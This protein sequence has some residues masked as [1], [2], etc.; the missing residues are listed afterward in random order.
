MPS[1]WLRA[2]AQAVAPPYE[3]SSAGESCGMKFKAAV[4]EFNDAICTHGV[5]R[6]MHSGVLRERGLRACTDRAN[7][8]RNGGQGGMRTH[9]RHPS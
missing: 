3:T 5:E 2:T 1:A 9:P 7:H 8:Q 6:H 4:D